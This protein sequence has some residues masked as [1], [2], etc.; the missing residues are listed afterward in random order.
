MPDLKGLP[1]I[2]V[3]I[4]S[5]VPLRLLEWAIARSLSCAVN[6]AA[7]VAFGL[8]AGCPPKAF[9][10]IWESYGCPARDGQFLGDW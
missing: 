3:V 1:A 6:D 8:A 5:I 7:A 4:V 2:F 9:R 10:G